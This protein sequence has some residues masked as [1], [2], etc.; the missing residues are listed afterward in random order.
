MLGTEG[1]SGVHRPR[2]LGS[3]HCIPDRLI[4]NVSSNGTHIRLLSVLFVRDHHPLFRARKICLQPVCHNPIHNKSISTFLSSSFPSIIMA[5]PLLP[6]PY[7]LV[8]L[9][10]LLL[11]NHHKSV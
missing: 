1:D 9:I 4:P 7:L 3:V 5:A 10:L 2:D 8:S 11:A 6:A